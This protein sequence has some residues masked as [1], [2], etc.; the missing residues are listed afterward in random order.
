MT[1]IARHFCVATIKKYSLLIFFEVGFKK[2]LSRFI[3]LP[4]LYGFRGCYC[5]RNEPSVPWQMI[6]L[7]G[8]AQ[9]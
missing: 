6:R 9:P 2:V 7:L 1:R 4:M 5:C 3:T 8:C